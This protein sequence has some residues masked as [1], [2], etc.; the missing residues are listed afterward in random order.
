[1]SSMVQ[2]RR[3]SNDRERCLLRLR[4]DIA[5]A[6]LQKYLRNLWLMVFFPILPLWR[7]ESSLEKLAGL[8]LGGLLHHT[9]QR[10]FFQLYFAKIQR[11]NS[12]FK[13]VLFLKENPHAIVGPT[14]NGSTTRLLLVIFCWNNKA[15]TVKLEEHTLSRKMPLNQGFLKNKL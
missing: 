15:F 8:S 7:E 4:P 2:P 6:P 12:S 1:M 5:R 14:I 9:P 3:L 13:T 10:S 11:S